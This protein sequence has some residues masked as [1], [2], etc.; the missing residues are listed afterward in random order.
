MKSTV[1]WALIFLNA[2]LLG[3][4][5]SR[6]SKPNIAAAQVPAAA[7]RRPGDYLM[8]SGSVNGANTGIVY[9]V[10]TT[11]GLLGAMSYDDSRHAIDVMPVVDMNQ[12]FNQNK[13]QT[14]AHASIN[15]TFNDFESGILNR[16]FELNLNRDFLN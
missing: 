3:A 5:Y 16:D 14:P 9:V 7:D 2:I 1:L 12:A 15:E 11:N 8:I 4:F 13:P 10:D 6:V